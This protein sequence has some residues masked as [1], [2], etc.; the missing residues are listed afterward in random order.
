M[1][2]ASVLVPTEV[3]RVLGVL[4][5]E[6]AAQLPKADLLVEMRHTAGVLEESPV[7]LPSLIVERGELLGL[8]FMPGQAGLFQVAVDVPFEVSCAEAILGHVLRE[9]EGFLS[10]FLN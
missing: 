8:V 6:F 4:Q 7:L 5:V 1:V 3:R 2:Q 9:A 10:G